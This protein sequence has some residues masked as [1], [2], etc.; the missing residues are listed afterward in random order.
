LINE[1]NTSLLDNERGVEED[2]AVND[3]VGA[4]AGRGAQP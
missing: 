3:C 1:I 2:S 4:R